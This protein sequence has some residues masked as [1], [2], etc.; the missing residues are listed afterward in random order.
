MPDDKIAVVQE[1][2]RDKFDGEMTDDERRISEYRRKAQDIG[3][4]SGQQALM[5]AF[6]MPTTG[7]V[8][9]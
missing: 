3:A 7:P 9:R 4:I 8:T 6:A 1:R 2:L 5:D